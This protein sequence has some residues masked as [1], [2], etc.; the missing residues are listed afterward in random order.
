[1]LKEAKK[2]EAKT[3]RPRDPQ[4]EESGLLTFNH[5]PRPAPLRITSS[6]RS[7]TI[8]FPE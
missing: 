4:V 6:P 8:W 2:E 5:P 7:L 3:A 1:M